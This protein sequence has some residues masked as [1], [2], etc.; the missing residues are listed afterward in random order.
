MFG[1]GKTIG[2][3]WDMD[4]VIVDSGDAHFLSWQQALARHGL[5]CSREFFDKT[6]GMNNRGFLSLLL[7]REVTDDELDAIAGLKEVLFREDVQG[8]LLPLPGVEDWVGRFAQAGFPQAVASSAPKENIDA[9]IGGLGLTA[10]FQALVSGATLSGKPDPATFLLAARQ[11]GIAP[12]NCLV[13]EDARVGVEAAKRGGMQCVAVCTTHAASALSG[14][15]K[16]VNRLNDLMP[17]DVRAL[18][19]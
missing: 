6:F 4:G 7:Q 17:D 18:F 11:L 9:I 3:L 14:A 12:E 8:S 16:V 19:S 15:G 13:I 2:I 10:S 1:I 5:S